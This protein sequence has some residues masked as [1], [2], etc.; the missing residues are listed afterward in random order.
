MTF[1]PER[2]YVTFGYLLPQIRLSVCRL[3][4]TL[5]HPTQTVEIFAAM[6]LCHFV[7]QP[8]ADLRAKFYVDRGLNARGVANDVLHV[9][10]CISETMQ[11]AASGIIN[12]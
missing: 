4:V 6:L 8:S 7:P 5:M 11:D 1:L 12:N 9:E 2:D 10:G 3:S